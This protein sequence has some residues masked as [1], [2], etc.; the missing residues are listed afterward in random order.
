MASGIT[1]PQSSPA[2]LIIAT[3]FGGRHQHKGGGLGKLYVRCH[4]DFSIH[5]MENAIVN[6]IAGTGHQNLAIIRSGTGRQNHPTPITLFPLSCC[7]HLMEFTIEFFASSHQP[8][9]LMN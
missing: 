8:V 6:S 2:L 5:N 3:G 9:F 7:K 1:L 4:A